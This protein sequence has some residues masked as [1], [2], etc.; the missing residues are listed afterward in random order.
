[1]HGKQATK[2]K[3][4]F[5][6]TV[7]QTMVLF[8]IRNCSLRIFSG[9]SERC[10][11]TQRLGSSHQEVLTRNCWRVN[12][13]GLKLQFMNCRKVLVC[14]RFY[15]AHKSIKNR[16][17]DAFEDG[18]ITIRSFLLVIHQWWMTLLVR[19]VVVSPIYEFMKWKGDNKLKT[20]FW[21]INPYVLL[22][23]ALLPE[24]MFRKN[25]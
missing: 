11:R 7:Y 13:D 10:S 20:Q 24:R 8:E 21:I 5:R 3:Q 1:M 17:R 19:S 2:F 18:Q 25:H 6:R 14:L 22:L 23:N 12:R 16:I 4:L 9:W 15:E